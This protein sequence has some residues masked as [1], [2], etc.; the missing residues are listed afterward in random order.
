M[1]YT[2]GLMVIL[3]AWFRSND[4]NIRSS[5]LIYSVFRF[6]S[7][8]PVSLPPS[9]VKAF[10]WSHLLC[11]KHFQGIL[12]VPNMTAWHQSTLLVHWCNPDKP[13]H[14]GCHSLQKDDNFCLLESKWTICSQDQIDTVQDI[15]FGQNLIWQSGVDLWYTLQVQS[16]ENPLC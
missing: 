1:E 13:L 3:V 6:W 7:N 9:K 11:V 4:I 15:G 8:D 14:L 10:T 16:I 2:F 5:G 12:H